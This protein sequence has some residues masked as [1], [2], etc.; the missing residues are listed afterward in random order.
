WKE[1]AFRLAC[2]YRIVQALPILTLFPAAP[3]YSAFTLAPSSGKTVQY[4]RKSGRPGSVSSAGEGRGK[5]SRE[6]T[7]YCTGAPEALIHEWLPARR[8]SSFTAFRRHRTLVPLLAGP[9]SGGRPL[10]RR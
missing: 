5:E 6:W 7:L 10:G 1:L 9:A 2:L 3:A 8:R 4:V